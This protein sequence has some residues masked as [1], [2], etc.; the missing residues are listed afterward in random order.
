M[1]LLF[2]WLFICFVL[3]ATD[4]KIYYTKEKRDKK[5][6]S[7]LDLDLISRIQTQRMREM[8]QYTTGQMGTLKSQQYFVYLVCLDSLGS[9]LTLAQV[10]SARQHC[11]SMGLKGEK[12]EDKIQRKPLTK[13]GSM[14]EKASLENLK[15]LVLLI[16]PLCQALGGCSIL[17][18]LLIMARAH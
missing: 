2:V 5:L 8:Q 16:H 7:I 9:E 13:R 12:G 10:E 18:M 17:M 11:V 4:S 15:I 3:L 14:K 1:L 6:R